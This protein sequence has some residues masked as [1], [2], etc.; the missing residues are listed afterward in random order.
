MIMLRQANNTYI[1][2]AHLVIGTLAIVAVIL[3]T[4]LSS[5]DYNQKRL[6]EI[7]LIIATLLSSTFLPHRII[8][9]KIRLI[10]P[11]LV[12]LFLGITSSLIAISPK[13]AL[14]ELITFLGLSITI[15]QLSPV[16]KIKPFYIL[17]ISALFIS[18]VITEVVFFTTYLAY[19]ISGNNF[20]IHEFFPAFANVRFF[21]QY[22]IWTMPYLTFILLHKHTFVKQHH[23]LLWSI[24]AAWWL[25][26]FSTGSRGATVSELSA[27]IISWYFFRNHIKSFIL[28]TVKLGLVGFITYYLLFNLLPYFLDHDPSALFKS[29]E[30]RNTTSDRIFLWTKA[31]Q[32]IYQR[33]LLGIGP[34]HYALS[35][36]PNMGTLNTITHP[37]NSLLQWGTEWGLPSLTAVLILMTNGFKKWF[38]KFNSLS[39][40]NVDKN[41]SHLIMATTIS[42]ISAMIYSLFSGVIVMPASQLTALLP[43]SLMFSLY[44]SGT[45]QPLIKPGYLYS[46]FIVLIAILYFYLLI[47]DVITILFNDND[48][49]EIYPHHPRFWL[50]GNIIIESPNN[51]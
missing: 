40:R 43:I 37:H 34:M 19:S 27:L 6:I 7:T 18:I 51:K 10:Q 2:Y 36:T 42:V 45:T 21:N 33:P 8:E 4:N 50:D 38:K 15:I 12:L 26:F 31:S 41:H 24:G 1:Q 22:Q 47:P 14:I 13:H 32:F 11:Y 46:A 48:I 29:L 30:L 28:I 3:S 16:W 5:L 25:I 39:L 35:T 17:I 23:G 44:Q 49:V 20:S 9:N